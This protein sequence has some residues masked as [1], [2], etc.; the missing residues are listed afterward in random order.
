MVVVSELALLLAMKSRA[1]MPRPETTRTYPQD[2][3]AISGRGAPYCRSQEGGVRSATLPISRV[4]QEAD[5]TDRA[6]L[7]FANGV[8]NHVSTSPEAVGA[9]R[10]EHCH[11][12]RWPARQLVRERSDGNPG[13]SSGAGCRRRFG[14]AFHAGR[15]HHDHLNGGTGHGD[16][17]HHQRCAIGHPGGSTRVQLLL[18][19]LRMGVHPCP[20]G[21]SPRRGR[22]S[23]H[24]HVP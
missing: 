12:R 4:I 23:C 18:P 6:V 15:S 17:A 9:G 1:L 22:G 10:A 3:I 16:D 21:G 20:D 5:R 13:C 14:S 7:L 19:H 24:N 11:P 2:F 8:S